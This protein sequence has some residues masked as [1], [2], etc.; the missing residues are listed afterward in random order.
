MARPSIT[1]GQNPSFSHARNK[2]AAKKKKKKK[3]KDK[4]KVPTNFSTTPALTDD[5]AGLGA[6][7]LCFRNWTSTPIHTY[8]IPKLNVYVWQI[9][10]LQTRRQ[11]GVSNTLLHSKDDIFQGS[12]AAWQL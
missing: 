6:R 1:V 2:R 3:K 12:A 4:K 9:N 11:T 5:L 7:R 10:T 8:S